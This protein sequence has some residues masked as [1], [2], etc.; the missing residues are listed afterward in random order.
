LI[1]YLGAT[2]LDDGEIEH[3]ERGSFPAELDASPVRLGSESLVLAMLRDLT[4]IKAQERREG[5]LME[6]IRRSEKMAS[7][8][9]LAA[10]IA[11]E[12]NNPMS[13]VASNV[14]RL[15]D[16]SKQLANLTESSLLGA[17]SAP[18]LTDVKEIA[19]E[20]QDIAGDIGE[21]V[22]RVTEIVTALREFSHGGSADASL[23]WIDV[24]RVIR[25][26]LS[27]IRNQTKDRAEIQLELEPL[28]PIRAHPSRIGQV[29]MNLVVNAAQAMDEHGTILIAST[30]SEDRVHI[31][32]EDNG[33]GI[34]PEHLPKIFDPFFTTKGVGQGTG[35]GLSVSQQIIQQHGGAL[36]VDSRQGHGTRFLIELLRDGPPDLL[37]E[38]EASTPSPGDHPDA[39]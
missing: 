7:I 6:K 9:Q 32:I 30:G 4:E 25:N 37:V 8:G 39:W 5:L 38:T 10:G 1:P 21:G 29:V 15:A 17:G 18:Q 14:N 3:P 16:H 34:P 13:Y 2:H 20:L 24:N 31:T 33:G 11:H 19:A 28:S 26:S 35:L 23:E 36:W 22:S 12:I 27:L